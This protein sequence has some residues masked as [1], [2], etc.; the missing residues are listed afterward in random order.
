MQRFQILTAAQLI[1][2]LPEQHNRVAFVAERAL[3]YRVSIFDHA[4]DAEHRRWQ[5]GAAVGF[6]IEADVSAGDGNVERAAGRTH[7]FDGTRELPHD[8]GLLRIAEVEAIGCTD[9]RAA[10]AR[11]VARRFGDRELRAGIWIEVNEPS[12]AVHRHGERPPGPLHTY[13]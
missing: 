6:V 10:G 4:N 5:H 8:L 3:Y 11:H 9:R 1:E 7:A 13:H 12:V 2:R